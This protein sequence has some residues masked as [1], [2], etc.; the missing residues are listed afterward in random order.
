MA[1]KRVIVLTIIFVL[2]N[3][4][5][6]EPATSKLEKADLLYE[7]GQY[8]QAQELYRDIVSGSKD[9]SEVT[10][11]LFQFGQCLTAQGKY[12][13][14]VGVFEGL[15]KKYPN[16]KEVEKALYR[17]GCIL[18]GFLKD[19]QRGL[20]CFDEILR[21]YPH[22]EYED[23]AL[24]SI[25]GV[26]FAKKNYKDAQDSYNKFLKMY[27]LS[28]YSNVARDNLTELEKSSGRGPVL[29]GK[30]IEIVSQNNVHTITRNDKEPVDSARGDGSVYRFQAKLAGAWKT[31][32]HTHGIWMTSPD[33]REV[34]WVSD[35]SGVQASVEPPCPSGGGGGGACDC[36][37]LPP[38]CT[39]DT[40]TIY[41][42]DKMCVGSP[43]PTY[44]CTATGTGVVECTTTDNVNSNVAG[45][46]TVTA[47]ATC[48]YC[49]GKR[50]SV[51]TM[52][53]TVYEV[54]S[55]SAGGITSTTSTPGPNETLF[56]CKGNPGDTITVTATPNPSGGW[57]D[58]SPQW[59]GW[60]NAASY[61]GSSTAQFPIDTAINATVTATCGTSSKAMKIIVVKVEIK[62][63]KNNDDPKE[64]ILFAD[65]SRNTNVRVTVGGTISGV[66][67]KY[68]INS[69][70]GSFNP[71][72]ANTDANGIAN[73]TL[74]AS[75][76]TGKTV[77]KT[78][79][80]DSTCLDT[81][82]VYMY[83]QSYSGSDFDFNTMM[84]NTEFTTSPA[85]LDTEAEI[86]TWL[87]GKTGQLKNKYRAVQN[88]A[89]D[90]KVFVLSASNAPSTGTIKIDNE[91][92]S[93]SSVRDRNRVFIISTRGANG[94][95]VASHAIDT[96]VYI[97]TLL[98]GAI[99]KNV[100]TITVDSTAGA[101]SSGT[102]KI[103]SED[104]TYTGTTATTFTG[105]TRG[106]NGTQSASHADNT[107]VFYYKTTVGIPPAKIIYEECNR[108]TINTEV[109]LT[110]LQREQSLI[111][112]STPT[113]TQYNLAMGYN[114]QNPT[115][116]EQQLYDG[117][118]V[119]RLRYDDDKPIP[120]VFGYET[121]YGSDWGKRSHYDTTDGTVQV[122]L[123]T[124]NKSTYSF[125][126]YN[127]YTV[128]SNGGGNYLFFQ[129]WKVFG[130]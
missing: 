36:G 115:D 119:L 86:Q 44:S 100:T 88:S 40:I 121:G 24:Y 65:G 50:T 3:V 56:V 69:G 33:G 116:L 6:G 104:I 126:L 58:G 73:S 117:T 26:Q 105:C 72:E 77:I 122:K 94:T 82:N 47:T 130:F 19:V 30:P 114:A 45:T 9:I 74:T 10:H 67:I 64:T 113:E 46:Y 81:A 12:I 103:E 97:K 21:L 35:L 129:V 109:V 60:A 61:N 54:A 8:S 1:M 55:V 70:S 87:N 13:D 38:D 18:A 42:P 16:S 75:S 107:P 53:V 108:Q 15:M 93:Y 95:S 106:A 39:I 27:P 90:K 89:D 96:D 98:D 2:L 17:K 37:G 28:P 99:N 110:M 76:A 51:E 128:T 7:S 124:A 79:A 112:D 63:D 101:S 80:D 14:A 78:T 120:F 91:E 59:S 92:M 31:N 34:V 49:Y 118:R 111:T 68:E 57:P 62:D 66:P 32:M 11:A 125:F 5:Y 48:T 123:R 20:T 41:G 22:G 29:K 52:Q 83:K 127:P 85:N 71:T 102:L 84:T 43:D 4:P 23:D 25:A